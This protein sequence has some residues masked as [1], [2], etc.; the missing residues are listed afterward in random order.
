[1][2]VEWQTYAAIATVVALLPIAGITL[3]VTY[4]PVWKAK[5]VGK[6]LERSFGADSFDSSQIKA[7]LESYINPDCSMLDPS[8]EDDSRQ[9]VPFRKPL[10]ETIDDF[11]SDKYEGKHILLLADSGMGKTSFLLNYYARNQKRGKFK[12]KRI[13]IVPL[14]RPNVIN[15]IERIDN[16][17]TTI[18][19]LDAFD[20]DTEAIQ[21]HRDRLQQLM[22]ACSDFCR[23][24]LTCRTQFFASDE[25]IPRET[26]VAIV[27]PRRAG[28]GRIYKF[29]KLYLAPFTDEQV[30]KYVKKRF[31]FWQFRK[32]D[33]A[34]KIISAIPEL[35]VRPMLL[36]VVPDL[37]DANHQVTELYGLYE[38][39]VESWLERESSWIDK[40]ILRE[41]SE[42]LAV[43]IF[44]TRVWRKTERIS[45]QDL[46]KLI[47][48]DLAEIG[49]WQ[50]TTRSLLNRDA[51]GNHKF[52][53]RSIME[54][55]FISAFI[56]GRTA[57]LK[58][59]WT[60][61]ML[62]LFVS[63]ASREVRQR[64]GQV[65]KLLQECDFR[66]TGLFPLFEKGREPGQ[67]SNTEILTPHAA[68]RVRTK[69][70]RL[71]TNWS[72]A[73]V[74]EKRQGDMTYIC[75]LSSDLLFTIP[76]DNRCGNTELMS[77]FRETRVEVARQLRPNG[78]P[79]TLD[80][81]DLLYLIN[82][83][84][85][86]ADPFGYYWLSDK[87]EDGRPLLV[88]FGISDGHDNRIAMIG[89]R[90]LI[91]EE[92]AMRGYTVFK[93]VSD[94]HAPFRGYA[95]Y[96]REENAQDLFYHFTR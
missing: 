35:S 86:F 41:F 26:G 23:V 10:F 45:R 19:M 4:L 17:K 53:H 27:A 88:S 14:G 54:Y 83:A 93:H 78:R 73:F 92:G 8:G 32:R 94:H 38:F 96:V 46:S 36:A 58:E 95:V 89:T 29:Y 70:S 90:P 33:E 2:Q 75:D 21:D 24:V 71:N 68:R 81:M 40:D 44:Q 50:L 61:L 31:P 59:E 42:M 55:L 76:V 65:N 82:E 91:K 84:I 48:R 9:L 80:E 22:E 20:E 47:G 12:R 18:L 6:N 62:E 30:Q 66:C 25:E 28:Q 87:G 16:K 37:V 67:L 72:T 34:L 1:M 60:D 39:M 49:T 56:K 69:Y 51:D 85:P 52:A 74:L 43:D 79:P 7:A 11:L 57:C 3:I 63:W 64:T 5:R 13:A 77:L 15:K